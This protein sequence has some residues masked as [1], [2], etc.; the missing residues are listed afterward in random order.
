MTFIARVRPIRKSPVLF[1]PTALLVVRRGETLT[2]ATAMLYLRGYEN[3]SPHKR[4]KSITVELQVNEPV[5]HQKKVHQ[6][7]KVY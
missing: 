6:S 5:V 2:M 3:S 7:T 1:P 4:N